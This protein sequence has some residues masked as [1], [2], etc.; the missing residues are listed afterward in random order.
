MYNDLHLAK[1]KLYWYIFPVMLLLI[2]EMAGTQIVDDV[3][4]I[5]CCP[6]AGLPFMHTI[7][8]YSQ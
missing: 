4:A 1:T 3:S 7:R 6:A 8:T 2:Q 5:L